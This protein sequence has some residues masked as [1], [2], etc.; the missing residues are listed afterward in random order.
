MRDHQFGQHLRS[1]LLLDQQNGQPVRAQGLQALVAD[2]CGP[3]QAPLVAPL[4]ELVQAP[5]FLEALERR[6]VLPPDPQLAGA[7]LQAMPGELPPQLQA[8]LQAVIQGLLALP[9]PAVVMA[10]P[11]AQQGAVALLSFLAGALLVGVG[12]GIPWLLRMSK[13]PAPLPAPVIEPAAVEPP[14]ADP[15]AAEPAAVE[16]AAPAAPPLAME[17]AISSVA[18]LYSELSA[19]DRAG[20]AQRLSRAVADQFDPTFFA[21]FAQVDVSNLQVIGRSGSE[22]DLQGDVTFLYP[23]GSRQRETRT[24]RVD[25]SLDPPRITSSA[26]GRMISPR[27]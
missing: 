23:D 13:Q 17:R 9:E 22:L 20:A 25:T 26:F 3:A 12:V 21:Q 4:R 14:A 8:R 27:Q 18:N 19:G 7:L 5:V 16:P 2:L 15:P 24:Y 10:Q 6:P 11:S 1:Q